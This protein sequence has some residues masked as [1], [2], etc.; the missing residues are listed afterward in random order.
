MIIPTRF[1]FLFRFRSPFSLIFFFLK[2]FSTSFSL[3]VFLFSS[4]LPQHPFISSSSSSSLVVGIFFFFQL[5]LLLLLPSFHS[6]FFV[7]LLFFFF[8]L[9]FHFQRAVAFV[10]TDFFDRGSTTSD[11]A[12]ESSE[13]SKLIS[14]IR[15]EQVDCNEAEKCFEARNG[16]VWSKLHTVSSRRRQYHLA[17]SKTWATYST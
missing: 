5:C 10:V 2:N 11:W 15:W 12:R 9:P 8:A 17:N 3:V 6:S 14:W 13:S 16:P 1:F 7:L 4:P